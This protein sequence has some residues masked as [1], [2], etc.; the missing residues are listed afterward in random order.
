MFLH[1]DQRARR[2]GPAS[3]LRRVPGRRWSEDLSMR[4]PPA[5]RDLAQQERAQQSWELFVELPPVLVVG[6]PESDADAVESG[7]PSASD[8]RALLRRLIRILRVKRSE[9]ADLLRRLPGVVR[10]GA[11]V[12]LL[13]LETALRE[14]GIGCVLRR[15]S[16][17]EPGSD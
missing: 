7:D 11:R 10:R 6:F 15:R 1:I 16:E 8:A 14:A 12:D 4:S 17:P 9:R 5:A 13:P 2:S 3:S